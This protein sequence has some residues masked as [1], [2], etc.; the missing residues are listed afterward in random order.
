MTANQVKIN[1]VARV[2]RHT[3]PTVDGPIIMAVN[4]HDS[5]HTLGRVGSNIQATITNTAR[6]AREL[7]L[8]WPLRDVPPQPFIVGTARRAG[9][10]QLRRKSS[11]G[12]IPNCARHANGRN[13]ERLLHS[14]QGKKPN[15][16]VAH[17]VKVCEGVSCNDTAWHGLDAA[18]SILTNGWPRPDCHAAATAAGIAVV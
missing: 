15:I 10:G 3:A 16:T 2:D 5:G 6:E 14:E 17:R 7:R 13:S 18:V 9:D 4:G 11:L 8:P 1:A 12:V